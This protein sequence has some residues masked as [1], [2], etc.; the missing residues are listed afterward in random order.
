MRLK[1]NTASVFRKLKFREI[2]KYFQ[3]IATVFSRDNV[4]RSNFLFLFAF[5]FFTFQI[6]AAHAAKWTTD[7][8]EA[9]C[10]TIKDGISCGSGEFVIG[11]KSGGGPFCNKAVF[12]VP[13]SATSSTVYNGNGG[14]VYDCYQSGESMNWSCSANETCNSQH[15]PTLCSGVGSYSCAESCLPNYQNCNSS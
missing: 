6:S 5:T 14:F 7:P 13:S 1:L 2:K 11:A 8:N 4:F 12:A 15:R 3:K 10:G 9:T